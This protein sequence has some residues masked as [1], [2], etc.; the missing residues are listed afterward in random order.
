MLS[1]RNFGLRKIHFAVLAVMLAI[2]LAAFAQVTTAT[3][4]GT[5]SDPGGSAVPGA[6]VTARNVDTGLT[7]TVTSGDA[8]TYRLEF[9][10][11][12]KYDIEV[13]YTG[14][15]KA[16]LS[17]I[18]PA[19]QRHVSRGCTTRRGQVN[20][21][22]TVRTRRHP[23]S[24]PALPRSRARSSL[25]RSPPFRWLSATSTRCWI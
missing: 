22:V 14:F 19:G 15:K 10:P 24:T 8:G 9:L 1:I 23:K 12:G 17:G 25:R 7:R 13:T 5:I 6:Q 16:L 18:G 11:V 2:P 21:T 20:E 3:I 4:V